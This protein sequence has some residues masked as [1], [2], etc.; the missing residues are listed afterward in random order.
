[1]KQSILSLR[2]FLFVATLMVVHVAQSQ[3]YLFTIN[4]DTLKTKILEVNEYDVKY[5]DFDNLEGPVYIINKY[6]IDKIIYQ[7][8]KVEYFQPSQSSTDQNSNYEQNNNVILPNV[9]TYYELMKM[10]DDEKVNYLSNIG[11]NSIY[12]PFLDGNEMAKKGRRLR[13]TGIGLSIGG[14][15]LYTSGAF[16]SEFREEDGILLALLGTSVL[17]VGQVFTIV[18]IPISIIGG[19]KKRSAENMYYDFTMGKSFSYVQPELKFGLTQNG[20]GLSFKF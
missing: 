8:G 10:T 16:M 12:D 20:I 5:K 4:Y 2:V 3:D 17:M 1:M 14:A 18:S 6:R 13:F 9:I 19:V 15:V 7:N 11:V